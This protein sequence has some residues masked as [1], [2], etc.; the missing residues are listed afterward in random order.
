VKP[1]QLSLRLVIPRRGSWA[2][3]AEHGCN[4]AE[5]WSHYLACCDSGDDEEILAAA[6]LIECN[7]V[8]WN[9]TQ[10]SESFLHIG[11]W[12]RATSALLEGADSAGVWA[13]EESNLK[14]RR[15]GPLVILEEATHH[16]ALRLP[17]VCFDLLEFARALALATRPAL[18][19][20]IGMP[21]LAAQQYP[22]RWQGAG[23][24]DLHRQDLL[25]FLCGE[26]ISELDKECRRLRCLVA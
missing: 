21:A 7:G 14:M 5:L 9:S 15:Q 22:T 2:T 17:P 25:E 23:M 24:P 26:D 12:L 16:S 18:D 20:L 3:V 13:W 10:H 19:Q 6:I 8:V 11:S 4:T 1:S